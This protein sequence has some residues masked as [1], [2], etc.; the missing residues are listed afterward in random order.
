MPEGHFFGPLPTG[1]CFRPSNYILRLH[2]LNTKVWYLS[3][4][5]LKINFKTDWDK[6]K[7]KKVD[8]VLLFAI[9][10]ECNLKLLI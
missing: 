6:K 2:L 9:K 4:K 8:D 5:T 3:V 1:N 10:K 7:N